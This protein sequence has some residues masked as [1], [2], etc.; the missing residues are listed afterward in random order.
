MAFNRAAFHLLSDS[1]AHSL[2][3]SNEYLTTFM[4]YG[5]LIPISHY[6][7]DKGIRVSA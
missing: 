2:P 4:E 1:S 5:V 3:V 7:C 6:S